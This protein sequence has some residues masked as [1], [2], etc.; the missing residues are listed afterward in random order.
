[1]EQVLKFQ[2]TPESPEALTILC[3]MF[4]PGTHRPPDSDSIGWVRHAHLLKAP[5]VA[6]L[7]KDDLGV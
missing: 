2:G 4:I 6:L 5:L 7:P 3:T 1:M